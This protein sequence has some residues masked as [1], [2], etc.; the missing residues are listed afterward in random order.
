MKRVR[1]QNFH[2]MI[3]NSLIFKKIQSNSKIFEKIKQNIRNFCHQLKHQRIDIIE[4]TLKSDKIENF[5]FHEIHCLL[6][7]LVMS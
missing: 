5:S 2:N 4:E 7:C 3:T 6:I 1:G